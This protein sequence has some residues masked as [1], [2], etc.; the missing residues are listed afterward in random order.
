MSVL[1][2]WTFYKEKNGSDRVMVHFFFRY[3]SPDMPIG[4][5]HVATLLDLLF[6]Y[7]KVTSKHQ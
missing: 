3:V 6:R 7:N 2:L 4:L 5:L 1:A